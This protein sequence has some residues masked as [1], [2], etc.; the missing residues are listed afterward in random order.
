ML[1]NLQEVLQFDTDF[2]P[3]NPVNIEVARQ[4]ELKYDKKLEYYR[5]LY[6]R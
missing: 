6:P 4:K 5:D 3:E 2:S 1:K